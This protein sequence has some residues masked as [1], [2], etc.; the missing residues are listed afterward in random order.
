MTLAGVLFD[1]VAL[2]DRGFVEQAVARCSVEG[3]KFWFNCNP[4][5]PGHWFYTDWIQKRQ[6]KNLAYLHFRMEDN[7]SLS[8]A[9]RRRYE[10]LYSGGFYRRFVLGSG[11]TCRFGLPDV[12]SGAACG[13]EPAG[14]HAALGL[15]RLRYPQPLFDGVVG[16][17]GRQVVPPAGS[18]TTI[19]AGR[20]AAAPTRSTTGRWNSSV[21][22]AGLRG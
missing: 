1:E 14:L 21:R 7:P 22:T 12:Q 8:Q 15:L 13:A 11:P 9:M 16:G 19:P 10:S 5:Y 3:S 4:E 2:Q 6:E 20:A 17:E 18:T